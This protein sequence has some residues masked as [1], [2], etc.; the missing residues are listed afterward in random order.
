MHLEIKRKIL[1]QK[2]FYWRLK[3]IAKEKKIFTISFK[4]TSWVCVTAEN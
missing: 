3:G 4:Y 1:K 2:R